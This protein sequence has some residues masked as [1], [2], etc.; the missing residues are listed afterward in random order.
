ML[1][2]SKNKILQKVNKVYI[3]IKFHKRYRWPVYQML[4]LMPQL[5]KAAII[6]LVSVQLIVCMHISAIKTASFA[7]AIFPCSYKYL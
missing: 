7:K 2:S 4:C 1:A 5:L 6:L 3:L